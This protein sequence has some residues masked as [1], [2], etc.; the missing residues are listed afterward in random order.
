MNGLV[1][2]FIM[3]KVKWVFLCSM[4]INDRD[5]TN[6]LVVIKDELK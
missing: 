1:Y 5:P 3:P 6:R 4:I 2:V